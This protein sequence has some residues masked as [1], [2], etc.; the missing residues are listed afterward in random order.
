MKFPEEEKFVKIPYN[1]FKKKIKEKVLIYPVNKI[2]KKRK[3]IHYKDLQGVSKKMHEFSCI[4]N[5]A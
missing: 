4:R 1:Q 5:L 2:R 3:I